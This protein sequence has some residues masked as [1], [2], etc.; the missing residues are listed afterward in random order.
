V[1]A[2]FRPPVDL[3][4]GQALAAVASLWRKT[5][6]EL[7]AR[8]GGSSMEPALPPGTEVV[9][10]CGETGAPGDVVAFLADG[11]L[12]VHRVVTCAADGSWTL[13]RGDARILPDVPVLDPEAIV[14]RVAG[15]WRGG[16]L[17]A[18]PPHRESASRRWVA[19]AFGALLGAHPGIGSVTLRSIH[20][21][22]RLLRTLAG[23][24]LRRTRT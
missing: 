18:V 2:G 4:E 12:V 16:V 8:F 20:T 9:L 15:V 1:T 23:L 19:G 3:V 21:G 6:R 5:G 17:Q 10:R 14:G 22:S 24:I 13:T 11:R 7:R